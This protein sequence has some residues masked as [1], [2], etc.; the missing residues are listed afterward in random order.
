M[1]DACLALLSNFSKLYFNLL[2]Y[3]QLFK[4]AVC[5]LSC[6]SDTITKLHD[7]NRVWDLI[8]KWSGRYADDGVRD[9]SPFAGKDNPF[10]IP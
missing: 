2:T 1:Q 8:F 7:T 6:Y 9:N 3:L 10:K 4:V 5:D